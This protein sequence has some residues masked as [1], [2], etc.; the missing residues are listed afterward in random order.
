MFPLY[1]I[2]ACL[3]R[4]TLEYRKIIKGHNLL[5]SSQDVN[6]LELRKCRLI[7]RSEVDFNGR[8]VAVG[9]T[10]TE[11]YGKIGVRHTKESIISVYDFIEAVN[12][13]YPGFFVENEEKTGVV[14]N[15]PVGQTIKS[16]VP[17]KYLRFEDK[18]IY[19]VFMHVSFEGVTSSK[20]LSTPFTLYDKDGFGST[21]K[22]KVSADGHGNFHSTF[23]SI[24]NTIARLAV[25]KYT[26]PKM[27][28]Y[29]DRF[30]IL[31]G[32]FYSSQYK[33]YDGCDEYIQLKK[34]LRGVGNVC[35]ELDF[36]SGK[37][38]RRVRHIRVNTPG[39]FATEDELFTYKLPEKA[40]PEEGFVSNRLQCVPLENLT[41]VAG[42]AAISEDGEK[43]L[44]YLAEGQDRELLKNFLA[45]CAL[46]FDFAKLT[47]TE[48][49]DNA[50]ISFDSERHNFTILTEARPT[51]FYIEYKD[52]NIQ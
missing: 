52:G 46:E 40:I 38:V 31:A 17:E 20:T 45:E 26:G 44:V 23:G 30:A 21:L 14:V 43:L 28:L 35:D 3:I 41:D 39:I 47:E 13:R 12:E 6:T 22:G 7:G 33:E 15:T 11:G 2:L 9:G 29:Y 34:P 8:L 42:S 37:G 4:K 51:L 50:N 5:K 25:N 27:T 1:K 19:S 24:Y 36:V 49:Q 18:S 32:N 16:L 48:F 10:D